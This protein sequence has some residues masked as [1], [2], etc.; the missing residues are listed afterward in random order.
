MDYNTGY[1]DGVNKVIEHFGLSDEEQKSL[2]ESFSEELLSQWTESLPEQDDEEKSAE[3]IPEQTEEDKQTLLDDGKGVEVLDDIILVRDYLVKWGDKTK[4]DIE[5]IATPRTNPDGSIGEYF[6][7]QTDFSS[8][9]VAKGYLPIDWFHR[10]DPD[11]DFPKDDILGYVDLKSA[12]V[13]ETGLL[14]TKILNRRHRFIK[15]IQ[16]LIEMGKIS[17][18]SEPYQDMVRKGA[19]GRIEK[20]GLFRDSLTMQPMEIRMMPEFANFKSALTDEEKTVLLEYGIIA[21]EDSDTPE[22]ESIEDNA[23][24]ELKLKAKSM[25]IQLELDEQFI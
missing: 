10:K 14:V 22:A 5:G 6:T 21:N 20:W 19:D 23:G 8:E 7:P 13:D 12:V 16:R 3:K 2:S 9:Q 4:K 15:A 24:S 18:S 11:P 25:L 17:S 1:I